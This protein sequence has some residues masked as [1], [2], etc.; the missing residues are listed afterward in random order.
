MKNVSPN[1]PADDNAAGKPKRPDYLRIFLYALIAY[2]IVSIIFDK[3]RPASETPPAPVSAPQVEEISHD[4]AIGFATARIEG[5]FNA[6][7]LRLDD[8]RLKD[9]RE[10]GASDSPQVKVLYYAA[11]DDSSYVES[12][13]RSRTREFGTLPTNA[14]KWKVE[15]SSADSLALS[16]TNP[17]GA[18]FTKTY[19][20]DGYVLRVVDAV[21]NRSARP[22]HIAPY[23]RLG[24]S[25]GT[26]PMN[27]AAHAGFAGYLGG[28]LEELSWRDISKEKTKAFATSGGWFGFGDA[29]FMSAFMLGTGAPAQVRVSDPAALGLAA[30]AGAANAFVAEYEGEYQVVAPKEKKSFAHDFYIGA[31][32]PKTLAAAGERLGVPRF[33]LAVDYGFF[34]IL[35]KPFGVILSW[36]NSFTS[37]FGVAII[38]FTILIRIALFPIARKS[39]RSMEKMKKIQPEVKRLQTLYAADKAQMNL[40]MAMLYKREKI[41]PASGCLPLLLQLPV[42][43]ALYK[44]LIIS[45]E[46]RHAPFMLWLTDLSA[47]DPTS[48]FNLFG[49]LP[50]TP[51]EWL[52][53]L[54]VLPILMGVTMWV[55]QEMSPAVEGAAGAGVMKWL[56]V[57]FTIMFAGLPSGL[58]LYW[59]INNLLSIAQQKW[60]K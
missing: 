48:L 27:A 43:I 13:L 41:N 10:T 49:L 19:G 55:Q 26:K 56:P 30:P 3:P 6:T 54:G 28:R 21:D 31:K 16:W 25:V 53:A 32:E 29:Y 4:R 36:L 5:S 46:M 23:A 45:I 33:D 58:V 51:W 2:L 47:P 8:L 17:F 14:T 22:L 34:Y 59:T 9:Y 38:L 7:G 60:L 15:K 50:Y 18:V 37:N 11:A 44:A 35:A 20:F 1:A 24:E 42:F 39:F 57:I 12:G 52:P 40:Q